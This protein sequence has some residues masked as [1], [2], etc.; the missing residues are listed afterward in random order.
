MMVLVGGQCRKVGKTTA[1]CQIIAAIPEARWIAYKITPHHHAADSS[2]DPDT[3]RYLRAGAV[4]A[5]LVEGSIPQLPAGANVIIESNAAIAHCEPDVV[6]YIADPDNAD[7][8]P[9]AA[10]VERRAHFRIDVGADVPAEMIDMIR[11][12]LSAPLSL[13][14]TD[15]G[16]R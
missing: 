10:A 2:R 7:V 14:Q 9:S 1:V 8:K 15:L 13:R 6:L 4:F 12:L 16:H 5:E 11:R 3:E